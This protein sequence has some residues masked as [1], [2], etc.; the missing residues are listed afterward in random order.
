MGYFAHEIMAINGN[1]TEIAVAHGVAVEIFSKIGFEAL[2]S[3]IIPQ[4]I[5]DNSSFFIAPDGSKEGW[6]ESNEG[7]VVRQLLVDHL[8]KTSLDWAIVLLGGDDNFFRVELS[9]A[10]NE[11]AEMD[12][13]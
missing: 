5:G 6:A 12:A 13:L 9:S 3:P 2:I 4:I 7:N 10:E 11:D 8:A 1:T